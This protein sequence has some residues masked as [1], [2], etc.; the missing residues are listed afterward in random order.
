M[1]H[2][3]APYPKQLL[4]VPIGVLFIISPVCSGDSGPAGDGLC[5]Y[6]AEH[7][8]GAL[9]VGEI[10]TAYVPIRGFADESA[11]PRQVDSVSRPEAQARNS[12][13][14]VGS[15]TTSYVQSYTISQMSNANDGLCN[16]CTNYLAGN[17]TADRSETIYVPLSGYGLDANPQSKR[18][19]AGTAIY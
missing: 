16:Y 5:N 4:L 15:D 17:V 3:L 11:L 10:S 2:F 9:R 6:C 7:S 1:T 14:F 13:L 12:V 19:L 18:S 8:S